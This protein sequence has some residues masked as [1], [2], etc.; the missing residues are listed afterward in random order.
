MERLT[1]LYQNVY[2]KLLDAIRGGEYPA[3]SRLPSV[4]ELC[5]Q[6]D[7]SAIT[8]RRAMGMLKDEGYVSRQ[9]RIGTIVISDTPRKGSGNAELPRIAMIV[10]NFDDTFGARVI[11][12]ALNAAVDH[13]YVMLQQ[14][15]GN[16]ELEKSLIDSA[17]KGGAQGLI[18]LPCNSDFVPQPVIDLISS[19]FPI[20]I[21]DRRFEGVPVATVAS[22]NIGGATTATEYLL[23]LGHRHVAFVRSDCHV[24]SND[25]RQQG[26]QAAHAYGNIALDDTLAFHGVESTLPDSTEPYEHDIERL[27]RFVADHPQVTAFLACEYNIALMLRTAL[28]RLGKQVPRDASIICF[29]HPD[30]TFDTELFRFTNVAQDQRA[31]GQSAIISTLHQIGNGSHT[32]KIVVPTTLVLGQSTAKPLG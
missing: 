3:G 8:V 7:V 13:A 1:M 20:T 18:L 19:G 14:S 6:Y 4:E 27:M 5:R 2:R 11:K 23:S 21:L 9:P 22:D 28:Q 31:L 16:A 32:E 25:E 15:D 29:D 24:T 30:A 26:W 12:G 17:I 10:T